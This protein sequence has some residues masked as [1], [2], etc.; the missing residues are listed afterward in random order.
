MTPTMRPPLLQ[1]ALV[2]DAGVDMLVRL[3]MAGGGDAAAEGVVDSSSEG[4]RAS[5][6]DDP[7]TNTQAMSKLLP[8][9]PDMLDGILPGVNTGEA[10]G[11]AGKP[12]KVEVR[13]V[14]FICV[15]SAR[16]SSHTPPLSQHALDPLRILFVG[17]SA[18]CEVGCVC[19]VKACWSAGTVW[20]AVDLGVHCASARHEGALRARGHR[21]GPQRK[22]CGRNGVWGTVVFIMNEDSGVWSPR[23]GNGAPPLLLDVVFNMERA[24]VMHA[25]GSAFHP[26][27]PACPPLTH[28]TTTMQSDSDSDDGDARAKKQTGA[29]GD[30]PGVEDID[31]LDEHRLWAKLAGDVMAETGLSPPRLVRLEDAERALGGNTLPALGPST[32]GPEMEEGVGGIGAAAGVV[33]PGSA[34]G[35]MSPTAPALRSGSP[36]VPLK[37]VTRTPLPPRGS[38]GKCGVDVMLV[39]SL[40]RGVVGRWQRVYFC[41]ARPNP[42]SSPPSPGVDFSEE[43]E[44]AVKPRTPGAKPSASAPKLLSPLARK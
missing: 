34:L 20:C 18:P 12:A 5:S 22:D 2:A 8:P 6:V 19:P 9:A 26:L 24:R 3:M 13:S 25:S 11:V 4:G 16:R 1:D 15:C 41:L 38:Q 39:R 43:P 29:P 35:P 42:L 7:K 23:M 10:L 32:A 27:H 36:S 30:Y 17:P 21:G 37:P 14:D 33:S 40:C 44:V 31:V 28:P